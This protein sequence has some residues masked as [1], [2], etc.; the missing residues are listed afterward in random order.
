MNSW[1]LSLIG[2]Y[3]HRR[4]MAT[5]RFDLSGGGTTDFYIDGRLVTTYP[6]ALRAIA[7]GMLETIRA[8]DLMPPGSNIVAPAL[9]G[10]PVAAALSLELDIPFVIDRGAPKNHGMS[11]RFEGSFNESPQC[12]VVDD[13]I[14]V[15]STVLR[16]VAGLRDLGKI[17]SNVLVVVDRE[18]GGREALEAVGV[19]LHA[20]LTKSELLEALKGVI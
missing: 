5:G 14:T 19:R 9:S 10:V 1:K 3:V 6:P 4:A 11:K 20:L 15:A 8:R 12:L 2:H 7:T 17:V 18:E 13:L 16:T